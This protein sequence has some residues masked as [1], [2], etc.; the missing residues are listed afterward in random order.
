MKLGLEERNFARSFEEP[1][2]LLMMSF[3]KKIRAMD[4]LMGKS[5]CRVNLMTRA[6]LIPGACGG[7]K[8]SNPRSCPLSSPG[9]RTMPAFTRTMCV[10]IQHTDHLTDTPALRLPV[11]NV[12]NNLIVGNCGWGL[13]M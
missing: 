12:A 2:T 9:L 3:R 10:H 11:R 7:R 13:G 8:E 4:D 5:D 6:S 1:R